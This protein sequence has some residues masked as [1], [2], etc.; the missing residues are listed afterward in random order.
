MRWDCGLTWEEK[1][2]AKE[3]WHLWFAWHPVRL[4]PHDCRWLETVER[5]GHYYCYGHTWWVWKYQEI[6]LCLK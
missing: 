6:E 2:E 3:R 1:K 5:K 4:G